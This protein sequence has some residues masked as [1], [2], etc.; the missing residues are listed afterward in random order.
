MSS[1]EKEKSI[2]CSKKL[3]SKNIFAIIMVFCLLTISF[4]NPLS[5]ALKSENEIIKTNTISAFGEGIDFSIFVHRIKQIDEIDPNVHGEADWELRMYVNGQKKTY[6]CEGDNVAVDRIFIWDDIIQE[7]TEE[8]D[9]KM[10]LR[11]YDPW[12][13]EDD[14]ADISGYIDYYYEDKDY[15]DTTDFS[16]NRPTVFKRTYNV[17]NESWKAED[18]ENDYLREDDDSL[19]TWWLTSGNFDGSTTRDE[20][21]ACIWFNISVEN[22]PPYAPEKPSGPSVGWENTVYEFSTKSYDPNNDEIKFGWDWNDDFEV[23]ELTGFYESWETASIYHSWSNGKV[24]QLRVLA[25]DSKGLTS[26]WSEPLRVE[27]NGPYGKSGMDVEEWSLGHVYSNYFDHYETQELISTLR[28][29]GNVVAAVAT[30]ITTVATMCGVPLDIAS[31]TALA[32]AIIRLSV[33]VI[34]MMDRGMGIYIRTYVIEVGDVPVCCTSYIWSQSVDANEGKSPEDNQAPNAPA[35]PECDSNLFIA[36]KEYSFTSKAVD[37]EGDKVTLLFSWGDNYTWTDFC[38]SDQEITVQ[39]IWEEKGSYTVKVK[40]FD[41]YGN[42]S[43]WSEPFTLEVS[44]SKSKDRIDLSEILF[45][46]LIE[47]FHIF[48]KKFC[49]LSKMI[50][51]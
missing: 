36:G 15:D 48:N 20:N 35:K 6:E 41:E 3:V 29:G 13:D 42:E 23:D 28:S 34:N 21:D 39:Y 40:A 8:L 38:D 25:I 10:E 44:K 47:I 24:Y 32:G 49:F 7:D 11:D 16:S 1:N 50:S 17:I 18:D 43:D 2:F 27:I 12:P 51:V 26:E 4:L 33:E 14:I 22:K 19:L 37:P 31:A 30:I 5:T 9:I 46:Q 45:K